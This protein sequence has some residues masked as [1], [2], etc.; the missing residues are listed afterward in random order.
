MEFQNKQP[1]IYLIAGKARTGKDTIGNFISENY[2]NQKVI[3]LQFSYYIKE[4]AKKVSDWNGSED[5]KP[6]EFL[7]QLGTSLIRGQID[8]LFFVRRMCED[9]QVYSYFYDVI[10]ISDV[11]YEIEIT[12]LQAKFP[13]VYTIYTE[14]FHQRELTEEQQKHSTEVGLDHYDQYDYKVVNDCTLGEL[15]EKIDQIVKEVDAL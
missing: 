15:K 5:T 6:R 10:I 13:N 4:Y 2:L 8:E 14:R 3:H 1:K 7:Q 11:R 12:A 9:I